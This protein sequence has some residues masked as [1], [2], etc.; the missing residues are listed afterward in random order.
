MLAGA[1]PN[2]YLFHSPIGKTPCRRQQRRPCTRHRIAYISPCPIR[3]RCPAKV[4]ALTTVLQ[5][6]YASGS[7][8]IACMPCPDNHPGVRNA[9][10]NELPLFGVSHH[11]VHSYQYTTN[12]NNYYYYYYSIRSSS[13]SNINSNSAATAA[14]TE[15][16][17]ATTNSKTI[18]AALHISHYSIYYIGYTGSSTNRQCSDMYRVSRTTTYSNTSTNIMQQQHRQHKQQQRIHT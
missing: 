4:F 18:T 15:K 17:T 14:S 16:N 8:G 2:A 5:P 11:Y 6:I 12:S 10:P 1:R 13:Y 7:I 3:F 9:A